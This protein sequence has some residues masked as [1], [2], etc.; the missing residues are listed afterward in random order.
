MWAASLDHL[1][2]REKGQWSL[3]SRLDPLIE[4]WQALELRPLLWHTAAKPQVSAEPGTSREADP[5]GEGSCSCQ[6]TANPQ[7]RL[8]G[9]AEAP[10]YLKRPF[11]SQYYLIGEQA[12]NCSKAIS[13]G[14]SRL[15]VTRLVGQGGIINECH[16]STDR[17]SAN[18]FYFTLIGFM[19]CRW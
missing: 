19:Q 7:P 9:V 10:A 12:R 14:L 13:G 15:A 2:S 5:A 4:R 17:T 16:C 6:S 1:F 8:V 18:C 3:H 11:I